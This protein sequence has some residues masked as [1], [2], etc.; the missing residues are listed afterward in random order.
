MLTE[1]G[2]I[3]TA[4]WKEQV[5][6]AQYY[7]ELCCIF[8][9]GSHSRT[10]FTNNRSLPGSIIVELLKIHCILLGFRQLATPWKA[11]VVTASVP[12][13]HSVFSGMILNPRKFDAVRKSSSLGQL[14]LLD[15]QIAVTGGRGLAFSREIWI[16]HSYLEIHALPTRS[17]A[18][19][20]C[21]SDCLQAG[22]GLSRFLWLQIGR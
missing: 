15:W 19:L 13:I 20:P 5:T 14:R 18:L 11:H 21:L 4:V 1:G 3:Q 17:V 2:G 10:P 16:N 6:S 9:N 22:Q 8:N 12:R 7:S